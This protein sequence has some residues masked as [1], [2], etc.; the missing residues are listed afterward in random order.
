M[1]NKMNMRKTDYNW[2]D[3]IN[4]IVE[5]RMKITFGVMLEELALWYITYGRKG[6]REFLEGTKVMTMD[7]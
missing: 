1:S 6:I 5:R 4:E 7:F 2:E 3:I